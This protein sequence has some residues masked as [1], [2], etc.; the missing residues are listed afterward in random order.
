MSQKIF[1]PLKPAEAPAEGT[2]EIDNA[3]TP[4]AAAQTTVKPD[5]STGDLCYIAAAHL[6]LLGP[7]VAMSL[8]Q[9]RCPWANEHGEECKQRDGIFDSSTLVY[10][11]ASALAG[12]GFSGQRDDGGVLCTHKHSGEHKGMK[13]NAN[14][15]LGYARTCGA[16][17]PYRPRCEAAAEPEQVGEFSLTGDALES[18]AHS[19][20][21]SSAGELTDAE[22]KAATREPEV[23]IDPPNFVADRYPDPKD[24]V[25][26]PL[27]IKDGAPTVDSLAGRI[28]AVLDIPKERILRSAE[29]V[30][31]AKPRV[32]DETEPTP[33]TPQPVSFTEF[34][35]QHQPSMPGFRWKE[36]HWLIVSGLES[37]LTVRESL[38]LAPPRTGRSTLATILFPAWLMLVK[39]QQRVLVACESDSAAKNRHREILN[40]FPAI[41]PFVGPVLDENVTM[42]P[43]PR[44][45]FRG[46]STRLTGDGFNVIV[47]DPPREYTAKLGA[48]YTHLS[49]RLA[50]GGSM[51]TITNREGE[52]DFAQA[53][54][55]FG[56]GWGSRLQAHL[57]PDV[58]PDDI[59]R[60]TRDFFWRYDQGLP[61]HY[62][63]KPL[64]A[65]ASPTTPFRKF[66]AD[67]LTPDQADRLQLIFGRM[68][69]TDPRLID[70]CY[71]H[72]GSGANGKTTLL[73]AVVELFK[74]VRLSGALEND[75]KVIM[76][77]D[78]AIAILESAD[79]VAPVW[80][81]TMAT[82][83]TQVH[84]TSNRGVLALDADPG[85]LRRVE[86]IR[87]EKTIPA[88]QRNPDMASEIAGDIDFAFWL[89]KGQE[90][91]HAGER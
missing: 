57:F 56:G 80:I 87:W 90:R 77:M 31:G 91:V 60:T 81:K 67:C 68:R 15:F 10:L 88:N 35:K 49:T 24:K 4:S 12:V 2:A 37:A 26:P 40:K 18:Y 34:V 1:H 74:G 45:K 25:I 64:D 72:V 89:F 42:A 55:N 79:K 36:G 14:V 75:A 86:V 58:I 85:I 17:L 59:D 53:V 22:F 3:A 8:Y 29:Q 84:I 66:L 38:I 11:G 44:L 63:F 50:P 71:V 32:I 19:A 62:G 47:I 21:G 51:V 28:G 54:I 9:L 13:L 82:S 20:S 41:E 61:S 73:S 27:E 43:S 46:P 6:G 83:G 52:N 30:Y 39:G 33:P 5:L 23:R 16:P 48:H 76:H 70:K 65:P 78:P 7:Q 69:S